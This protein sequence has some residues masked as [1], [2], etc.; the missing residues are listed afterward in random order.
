[1]NI[2]ERRASC[3]VYG[4]GLVVVALCVVV[5]S[6]AAQPHPPSSRCTAVESRKG[7]Q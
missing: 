2:E 6:A 1:V 7:K 4:C 5:L 3:Q